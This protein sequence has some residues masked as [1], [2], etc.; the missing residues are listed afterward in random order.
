MDSFVAGAALDGPTYPGHISSIHRTGKDG[1]R[2]RMNVVAQQ[3]KEKNEKTGE[4]ETEREKKAVGRFQ[5]GCVLLF[6][7]RS[8]SSTAKKWYV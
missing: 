4:R 5:R 1:T 2:I 7:C 6:C 8:E 3:K